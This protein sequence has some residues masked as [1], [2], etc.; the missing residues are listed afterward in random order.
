MTHEKGACQEKRTHNK[1]PEDG[2][3]NRGHKKKV[4]EDGVRKRGRIKRALR[5]ESGTDDS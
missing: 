4:P 5:V 2:V 1:V 3:R